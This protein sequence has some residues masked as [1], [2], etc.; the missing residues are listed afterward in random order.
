MLNNIVGYRA[1]IRRTYIWNEVSVSILYVVGSY[2]GGGGLM[3]RGLI[4]GGLLYI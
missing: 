3:N 2:W 1:Y 4:V